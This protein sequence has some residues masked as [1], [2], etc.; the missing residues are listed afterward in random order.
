LGGEPGWT[1]RELEVGHWPMLSVPDALVALLADIA[2][3]R[4]RP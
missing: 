3:E 1:F 2:S 4:V